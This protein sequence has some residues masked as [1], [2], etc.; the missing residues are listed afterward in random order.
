MFHLF[1]VIAPTYDVYFALLST[2]NIQLNATNQLA[3]YAYMV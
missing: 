3:I 1:S 2:T